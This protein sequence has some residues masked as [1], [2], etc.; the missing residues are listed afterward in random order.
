[1]GLARKFPLLTESEERE[2]GYSIQNALNLP[3]AELREPSQIANRI[4]QR[5]EQAKAKFINSNIRLVVKIAFEPRFRFRMD[6]ED[7]VQLA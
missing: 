5:A 3:D 6:P 4:L 1:M 2:L 7:L